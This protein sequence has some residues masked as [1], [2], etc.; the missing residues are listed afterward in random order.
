M[1]PFP[2][3]Y[4]L[5]VNLLLFCR[6]PIAKAEESQMIAYARQYGATTNNAIRTDRL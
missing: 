4:K 3:N 5:L 2:L 6:L 1:K